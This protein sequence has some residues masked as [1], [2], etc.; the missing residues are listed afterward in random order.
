V[1]LAPLGSATLLLVLAAGCA[2]A[3]QACTLIG[4]VTGVAVRVQPDL[5][6]DLSELRLRVCVG[7]TCRT[8]VVDLAP[9]TRSLDQGCAGRRPDDSCSAV[10]TPDGTLVGFVP[11]DDL[12]VGALR[13]SGRVRA[14]SGPLDLPVVR[15]AAATTYPNGADCGPG[16]NQASVSIDRT[17]IH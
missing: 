14:R 11:V 5:A 2:P 4:T 12:P 9:G 17:G 13:V 10:A 3:E 7:A 16:A 15:V 6:A 1:C 8:Q